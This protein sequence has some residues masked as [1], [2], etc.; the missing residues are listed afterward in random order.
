MVGPERFELS[1]SRPPDGR[2]NQT[3]LRPDTG[4]YIA[5]FR[6]GA[7]GKAHARPRPDCLRSDPPAAPAAVQAFGQAAQDRA[8]PLPAIP[9]PICE[10]CQPNPFRQCHAVLRV[11]ERRLRG[12]VRRGQVWQGQVGVPQARQRPVWPRQEKAAYRAWGLRGLCRFRR[13]RCHPLG[14]QKRQSRHPSRSPSKSRSRS[15]SM[16]RGQRPGG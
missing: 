11:G 8:G 7:S 2:A 12:Q 9:A 5:S 10:S 16:V 6:A 4:R 1:T 13:A 14:H 15:V 3:A